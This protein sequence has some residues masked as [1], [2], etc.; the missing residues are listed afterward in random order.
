MVRNNSL[1]RLALLSVILV[2][3]ALSLVFGHRP[4]AQPSAVP[5]SVAAQPAAAPVATKILPAPVTAKAVTTSAPAQPAP[6]PVVVQHASPPSTFPVTDRH[7]TTSPT[8]S[9]EARTLVQL[10]EQAHY[11]REAVHSS[12]YAE[13]IPNY[14][15]DLDGQ[16]LFFI[17]G[18][19]AAFA[20]Q[21]GKNVYWNLSALGNIDA[22]YDIFAVYQSRASARLTGFAGKLVFDPSKPDGQPRRCLDVSR[23]E[24]AFG[25]RAR[26]DFEE[27]LKETIGFFESTW[28]SRI[29]KSSS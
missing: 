6:K 7:F 9:T 8:L 13:V 10:L 23:A 27:G 14:M 16:R 19:K 11:N 3:G 24:T 12:N 2:V 29:R 28:G 26:T 17:T 5:P 4:A 21:F 1:R 20:T 18:D 22:A 15:G 25:F